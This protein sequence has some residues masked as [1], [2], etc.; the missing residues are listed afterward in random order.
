M[1]EPAGGAGAAVPSTK[2]LVASP[3]PIAS[4]AL[5]PIGRMARAPPVADRPPLYVAS[6]EA[7]KIPLTLATSRCCPEVSACGPG[8]LALR[9]TVV[10]LEVT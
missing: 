5:P 4:V 2:A 3:Q 10:P 7:A 1:L 8:Q 9:V 6:A